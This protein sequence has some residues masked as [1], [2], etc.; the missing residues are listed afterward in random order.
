MNLTDDLIL[1]LLDLILQFLSYVDVLSLLNCCR[2]V[3]SAPIKLNRVNL[4]QKEKLLL[5]LFSRLGSS[6]DFNKVSTSLCRMYCERDIGC[7]HTLH[8][9]TFQ[10]QFSF[11]RTANCLR[12]LLSLTLKSVI[13]VFEDSDGIESSFSSISSM[14]SLHLSSVKCSDMTRLCLSLV[15]LYPNIAQLRICDDFSV[16]D[17]NISILIPNLHHLVEVSLTTCH[18]LQFPPL[19]TGQLR[20]LDISRCAQISN[21]LMTSRNPASSLALL[22]CD[23]SYTSLD[24]RALHLLV[25]YSLNLTSLSA[26][27]MRSRLD[28]FQ[29]ASKSLQVLNIAGNQWLT[30]V[31]LDCPKLRQ[32]EVVHS[33]QLNVVVIDSSTLTSLDLSG[34]PEL[35]YLHL[36]CLRL[37]ELRVNDCYRLGRGKFE[38]KR[39]KCLPMGEVVT[40]LLSR[41]PLPKT[42]GSSN[43]ANVC[44][45][46][47]SLRFT[48]INADYLRG[49]GFY[50]DFIVMEEFKS[51]LKSKFQKSRRSS[52]L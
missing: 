51:S 12:S 41:C 27:R 11:L 32:I 44:D 20:Y 46:C 19:M 25:K 13:V 48:A 47:P 7:I 39:L 23:V 15:Q 31:A 49:T 52:S 14:R 43:F 36:R 38:E 50:D 9:E 3:I 17:A 21:V 35:E 2:R 26:A 6:L 4:L 30:L 40:R 33:E 5:P 28:S 16:N 8:I 22:C 34:L 1:S 42:G 24:Q 29:I 45:Y 18:L 10:I 37:T